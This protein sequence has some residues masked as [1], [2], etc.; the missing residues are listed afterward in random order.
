MGLNE[1]EVNTASVG[2]LLGGIQ[3]AIGKNN[4]AMARGNMGVYN[5]N[6]DN[7][8]DFSNSSFLSDYALTLGYRSPLGP[9]EVP[10][11]YS[12]QSKRFIAYINIGYTF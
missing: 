10:S 7:R 3:Y 2:T 11:M 12:D 5:F 9:I 6:D 8:L 1:Y 4:I